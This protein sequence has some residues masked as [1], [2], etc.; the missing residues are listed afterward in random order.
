MDSEVT[1]LAGIK[2]VT[3]STLQP[4][5]S[6][7]AFVDGDKTKLDILSNTKL[8]NV[9]SYG[10]VGDGSTD[11]TS[12]ITDAWNYVLSQGYYSDA[13]PSDDIYEVP[14][15]EYGLYFPA[16]DYVFNGPALT[17]AGGFGIAIKGDG[18]ENTRIRINDSYYFIS[19]SAS[20]QITQLT[21]K[22]LS[23]IGGLGIIKHNNT[24]GNVQ[25]KFTIVDCNFNG[26]W[27][28]HKGQ[29]I[30]PEKIK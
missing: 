20:Y 12:A 23:F 6:E 18:R 16:G 19:T 21:I 9:K 22:D 28:F 10:A 7:G 13:R 8:I 25:G 5:P 1:D 27:C 11:D 26:F 4:K 15:Q 17:N 2:S 3:I 29:K 24:S 30:S 14:V